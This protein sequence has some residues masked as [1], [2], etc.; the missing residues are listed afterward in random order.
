MQLS[1][2][3]QPDTDWQ[4]RFAHSEHQ[5]SQLVFML[6]HFLENR[7]LS[8]PVQSLVLR[9]TQF[10]RR[11][12]GQTNLLAPASGSYAG[13][14]STQETG[15]L[16]N[17]LSA[18]LQPQQLLRLHTEPDPRPEQASRLMPHQEKSENIGT[19]ALHPH[20]GPR[21]VWLLPEPRPCPRPQQIIAGP[22]RICSGWWDEQS[23]RRDYYVCQ[24]DGQILWLFRSP[25]GWFIHGVFA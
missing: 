24:Q 2:R 21:P 19:G 23:I 14:D 15:Q 3:Q 4:I 22:E 18:R 12:R 1:H 16:L 9:V 7:R 6:R 5:H 20:T 17:R 8:A 11:S 25:R 13:E 10:T